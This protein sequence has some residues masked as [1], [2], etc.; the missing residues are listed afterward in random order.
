MTLSLSEWAQY[1]DLLSKISNKASEE[2]RNAIWGANGKWKGVGLGGIPRE[3]VIDYAYALVTKYSEGSSELACQMYD[4]MAKLSKKK[5]PPA[6]PSETANYFDVKRSVESAI[7]TSLNPDYISSR[8]GNFVKQASQDTTLK[9]AQRDGA[10]FAWV[11][12]GDACAFCIVLASNGWR[13]ISKKSSTHAEHIHPNCSCAYTVRFDSNSGVAGYDPDKYYEEYKNAEGK[14]SK[15]KIKS[16]RRMQYQENKDKINAQK[17]EAY[18]ERQEA[19]Q[20]EAKLIDKNITVESFDLLK[21]MLNDDPSYDIDD[22]AI[23]K[24]REVLKENNALDK[25]NQ[26]SVDHLGEKIIFDTRMIPT[27]NWYN[28]KLVINADFF[29]NLSY[30]GIEEIIRNAPNTVCN[31]IEDCVIHEIAHA[32]QA[33]NSTVSVVNKYNDTPGVIG[34][35]TT[36]EK[37]MLESL[38]EAS[39]LRKHGKY[40]ELPIEIRTVLDEAAEELKLWSKSPI[41]DSAETS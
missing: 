6:E 19:E 40:D 11:P 38:A 1:R 12:S 21:Q 24:V 29:N 3:D 2:F 27:G 34:I 7:K 22:K 5:L 23:D 8:I 10:E 13:T 36:A 18:A 14:T 20:Q 16:M 35:S 30:D 25:F 15:E 4:K 9:N 39:V 37:D 17:R 33:N 28:T 26:I 41:V 31:S 32:D